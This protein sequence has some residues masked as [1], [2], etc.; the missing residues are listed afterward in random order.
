[1]PIFGVRNL[2]LDQ[3]LESVNNNKKKIQYFWSMDLKKGK[4]MQ[5]S[6]ISYCDSFS[7]YCSEEWPLR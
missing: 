1:M 4:V 5:F 7:K 2:T 6:A 3:Y